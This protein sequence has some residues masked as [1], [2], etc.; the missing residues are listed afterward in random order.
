MILNFILE[1]LYDLQDRSQE[2]NMRDIFQV[3]V[4]VNSVLFINTIV[5]VSGKII[6]SIY[7][8]ILIAKLYFHL[9]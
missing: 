5:Q 8:Q 9:P 3:V 2:L 7:P 1:V 6:S 4:I